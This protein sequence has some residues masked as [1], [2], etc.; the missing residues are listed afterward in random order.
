MGKQC[1]QNWSGSGSATVSIYMG[2]TTMYVPVCLCIPKGS[3]EAAGHHIIPMS[4]MDDDMI[5][6][7]AESEMMRILNGFGRHEARVLLNDQ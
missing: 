4:I 3:R 7:P 2:T 6:G 1:F 5:I